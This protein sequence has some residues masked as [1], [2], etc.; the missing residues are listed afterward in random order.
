MLCPCGLGV[1]WR[2]PGGEP[3]AQGAKR[4]G[5]G[6]EPNVQGAKRLGGGEP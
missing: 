1:A 2:G 6:G 5:G 4:L 3:N